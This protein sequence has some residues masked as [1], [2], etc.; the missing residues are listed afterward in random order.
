MRTTVAKPTKTRTAILAEELFSTFFVP[1]VELEVG[2]GAALGEV[3]TAGA[4][5]RKVYEPESGASVAL[6]RV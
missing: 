6:S 2:V 5:K 4:L 3:I 1:V